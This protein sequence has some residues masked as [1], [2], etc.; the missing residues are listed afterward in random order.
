ML[1]QQGVQPDPEKIINVNNAKIPTNLSEVK[2][3]L[4]MLNYCC[5]F[6]PNYSTISAPI[7]DLTRNNH[8]FTW[9]QEQQAAFDQLKEILDKSILLRFYNPNA[10][11][12]IVVDAS[13]HG[14]GAILAQKQQDDS[15]KPIR[16]G[17]RA[18]TDVET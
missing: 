17:S 5:P 13:P 15:V 8:V 6:I 4:G 1:N 16:F 14:L 11:T 18:L 9:Q 10:E 7:R 3:F 2:S 12:E